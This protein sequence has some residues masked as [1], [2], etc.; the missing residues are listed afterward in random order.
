MSD[1][2]PGQDPQGDGGTPVIGPACA[3]RLRLL[4]LA[5][6]VLLLVGLVTPVISLEKFFVLSNTVSIAGGVF[7]LAAEGKWF[8]FLVILVFSVLL[9]V[10]K[11]LVLLA[12]LRERGGQGERLRRYLGWMHRFGRWA[13]LDVF[14]IALLVLSVKLGA[15]MRVELEPGFYAFAL[16]ILLTMGV[17]ARLTG[18][19]EGEGRGKGG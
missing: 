15:A 16:A 13:M 8:L 9:P 6:L 3:R 1:R 12:V 5:A 17:T 2:P 18:L 10:A 7:Q 11:L 14:V 4:A 19:L